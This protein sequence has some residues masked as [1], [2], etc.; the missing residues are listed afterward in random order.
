MTYASNICIGAMANT[1]PGSIMARKVKDG[2]V[3]RTDSDPAGEC[4]T[5]G[6]QSHV[7]DPRTFY[8]YTATNRVKMG[9]SHN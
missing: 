7:V 9:H 8:R 5:V 1:S 6:F 4:S 2:Q 3:A